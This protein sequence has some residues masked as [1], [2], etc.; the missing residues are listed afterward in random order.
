MKNRMRE[1]RTSGSVRD[2]GGNVPIYSAAGVPNRRQVT[3]ERGGFMEVA[4][5]GEEIQRAGGERLCEV[6]QEQAAKH[7]RQHRDRQKKSR[8]AGD[9]AFTIRC[10]PAARN[11]E[12]NMRVMTPTPTIP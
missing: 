4:V 12:M 6:V 5:R 7:R 11:K 10:D 8:P 2:G 9:P 3:L 1:I